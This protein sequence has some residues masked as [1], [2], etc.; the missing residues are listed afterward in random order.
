MEGPVQMHEGQGVLLMCPSE[1]TVCIL[2]WRK[3]EEQQSA[4]Q[5]SLFDIR[6]NCRYITADFRSDIKSTDVEYKTRQNYAMESMTVHHVR[7]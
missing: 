2:K 6:Q 4:C 3:L 1:L 7:E 5:D